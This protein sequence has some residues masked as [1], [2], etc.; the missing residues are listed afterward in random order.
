MWRGGSAVEFF[1][2]NGAYG[3][4]VC[5]SL[6]FGFQPT[7]DLAH[8]AHGFGVG[9]GQCL[10]DQSRQGLITEGIGEIGFEHSQHRR[11]FF[12]KIVAIAFFELFDRI[13]ALLDHFLNYGQNFVIGEFYLLINFAALDGS[14]QQPHSLEPRGIP[15]P[16][17]LFHVSGNLFAQRHSW[18]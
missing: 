11:L 17:G 13:A 2:N 4:H 12:N 16:H 3:S 5:F 8:V 14:T 15:G 9:V 18:R 7:H 6:Q 1:S 10:G